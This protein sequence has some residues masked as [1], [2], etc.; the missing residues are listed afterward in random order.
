MA[1]VFAARSDNASFDARYAGGLSLGVPLASGGSISYGSDG[2]AIG[3]NAITLPTTGIKS[4]VWPGRKNTP[5]VRTI[6]VL[7]RRAPA[8][9]GA[10]SASYGIISLSANAGRGPTLTAE[11]LITSGNIQI[12]A[13]NELFA[14][15]INNLS[16]GAWSPTSGTWY[17]LFYSW[18]G[19]TG[20]GS[21]N[22]YIDGSSIGTVTPGAAFSASWSDNFFQE[23]FCG[24]S[25]NF[26]GSGVAYGK[27]NE[28]VI[29][30]TIVDPTSVLLTS[31]TGSLNG[32]SRTA[33]VEVPYYHGL[34]SVGGMIAGGL[35][36]G[37]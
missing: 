7:I 25:D 26:S 35:I 15:A 32:A 27:I 37:V 1:I 33:F 22:F 16:P 9:S 20:A 8:F 3:G 34:P 11:H 2:T 36:Q 30:D 6:S 13:R 10:P 12:M 19:T 21:F 17:D 29:W 28:I 31:G 24:V 5:G 14:T 4:L 18:D 23:I